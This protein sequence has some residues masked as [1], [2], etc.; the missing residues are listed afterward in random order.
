MPD[1]KARARRTAR[2]TLLVLVLVCA[3][4]V[5]A[6]YVAYYWLRPAAHMNYGELLGATPAPEIT[7]VGS[8]G[9]P[10]RLSGLRGRWVLLVV[11]GDAC[12]ARCERKLY[13]TRQ[14]RTMQGREHERIARVWLQPVGA[15]PPAAEFL[16]RN[17][18]MTLVRGD[19]R[20]WAALPGPEAA[21][22][23]IYLLDPLGNFVLRY[24]ADPDIKRLA[25]DLERLL[26]VSRI[27]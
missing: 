3:A 2:R 17:P 9:A 24:P 18:G 12:D 1:A 5:V 20:Q 11:D 15:P 22:A 7:G 13:A 4:P 26:R 25:K 8:D 14:A 16:A 27:G 10:F 19:P 23:S 6:S 21:A